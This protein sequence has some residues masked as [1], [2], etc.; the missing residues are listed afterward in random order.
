MNIVKAAGF[1]LVAMIMLGIFALI[2]SELTNS[3][4]WTSVLGGT[5]AGA[6]G[7]ILPL[8]IFFAICYTAY[9]IATGRSKNDGGMQ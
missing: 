8:V 9:R 6:L 5:F 1:F 3:T 7:S 4:A 2:H